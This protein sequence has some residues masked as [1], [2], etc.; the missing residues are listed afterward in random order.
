MTTQSAGQS[1][2]V[3]RG[4]E[5]GRRVGR[6]AKR[7]RELVRRNNETI[8]ELD[9]QGHNRGVEANGGVGGV[10][11][12][13]IIIAQQLQNLLPTL[14]AQVGSQGSNQGNGR[15]QNNDVVNDNI[16]GDVKNF[17]ALRNGKT[18]RVVGERPEENVRHLRSAKPKEQKKEDIV[19]VRNFPEELQDKGFIRPSSSPW[20]ASILF[21]K[22]NGGSFRMYIDYRELNKLIIKNRYP[23]PRID[24][25]F[26]QLQG[27]Q[28]FPKIDLR[29]GYHQ[30]RVHEDDI[31][32]T[33]FRTQY[34]HFE[35][36]VMPFDLTNTLTVAKNE[37]GYSCVC[38]KMFSLFE[39]EGYQMSSG[40]LQ[41]PEIP[42]WKWKRIA[43]DF[44]TKLPKT[45]SEHDTIWVIV[46]RLTKSVHFLPMREDYKMDMLA[47]FYLNEIVARYG[48]PISIISDHDSHFTS[49]F[50][51]TMQ[52]ALGTRLDMKTTENISQIK[53]MLK[54]ARDRQKSYTDK[55]RKPL[56]FSVGDH[57]LLKVSPWKG[58][59]RFR[60]KGKLAPIFVRPSE[61][62]ESVSLVA[63]RL[64]LLEEL[65]GVHDTFHMS[66]LRK[67]LAD[68]TLQIP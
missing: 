39:S 68:P 33:A 28:Y 19:V 21:V 55:R 1:T 34:G 41:Q 61:I 26:D 31:P 48:V 47:R 66:N 22:K 57:V 6:G 63:Y 32:K 10:P 15:N 53:D 64:R 40:L 45:S 46:D 62:T 16:Q 44:V 30:L 56:E 24:D 13:S 18:L 12:F 3:P 35:F 25:V 60:K 42:E 54:A 37:K 8:G 43:M 50:W 67:C 4:G 14:L 49:R 27:L 58:V 38:E 17:I 51:Q 23:L 65:N 2:A 11:G 5:T 59:V 20:G 29:S 9:G 36:T 52:E 7:T